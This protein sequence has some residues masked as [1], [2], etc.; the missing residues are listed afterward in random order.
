[1]FTTYQR[2]D[3]EGNEDPE[4]NDEKANEFSKITANEPFFLEDISNGLDLKLITEI[5]DENDNWEG[6]ELS[7]NMIV[8]QKLLWID[9]ETT[10]KACNKLIR[11]FKGETLI[12]K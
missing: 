9:S 3:K 8:G 10:I 4:L 11:I 12:P 6:K 5:E 7:S 1:M 2:F